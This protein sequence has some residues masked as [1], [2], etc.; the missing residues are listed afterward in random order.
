MRI[1]VLCRMDYGCRT[2][3]SW[4]LEVSDIL[5]MEIGNELEV[6]WEYRED[7]DLPAVYVDEDLA[8]VGLPGEEGYL[9]E[10][11]KHAIE[12]RRA[13]LRRT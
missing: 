1:Q 7:L 4:I 2:L 9:I 5:R 12:S 6:S 8:L 11:L 13:A 3:I 10:I